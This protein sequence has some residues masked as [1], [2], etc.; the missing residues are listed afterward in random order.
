[1]QP[2]QIDI[3]SLNG[4][5]SPI[6]FGPDE[7][8]LYA[9]Q[10]DGAIV[11][12]DARAGKI[13]ATVMKASSRATSLAVDPQAKLL[14]AGFADGTVNILDLQS[15]KSSIYRDHKSGVISVSIRGSHFASVDSQGG[16]I[17]RT[18][19][20]GDS[21]TPAQ[22]VSAGESVKFT[23]VSVCTSFLA[24]GDDSGATR[25]YSLKGS[26]LISLKLGNSESESSL[27]IRA[28]AISPDGAFLASGGDTGE[29]KLWDLDAAEKYPQIEHFDDPI[30]ALAF[31]RESDSLSVGQQNTATVY[32]LLRHG[33]LGEV[34]RVFQTQGPVR[35]MAISGDFFAAMTGSETGR[36]SIWSRHSP[37]LYEFGRA[38]GL[39]G[40]ETDNA[41]I[42]R[43]AFSGD[44]RYL[45]AGNRAGDVL[46]WRIDEI[47]GATTYSGIRAIKPVFSIHADGSPK[48]VHGL[49]VNQN[50][51]GLLTS[52]QDGAIEQWSFP[53][54]MPS[55][56]PNVQRRVTDLC[57]LKDGRAISVGDSGKLKL[58]DLHAKTTVELSEPYSG[59]MIMR[60]SAESGTVMIGDSGGHVAFWKASKDS[61]VLRSLSQAHLG[62]VNA[63]AI[64]NDG[65]TGLSGGDDHKIFVWDLQTYDKKVMGGHSAAVTSMAF[66]NDRKFVLSGDSGRKLLFWD[67]ETAKE[68]LRMVD[69]DDVWEIAAS[70]RDAIF[71]VGRRDGQLKLLD[72]RETQ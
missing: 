54:V 13:L 32:Q 17:L 5:I 20:S 40:R 48:G 18:L 41:G 68:M 44:G 7:N 71:I 57:W 6:S 21:S 56:I 30:S 42:N 25:L 1:M 45:F 33:R 66:S 3:A 67:P 55:V 47:L 37:G 65:K 62:K 49:A 8:R 23:A 58:T 19:K 38:A 26:E 31:S 15:Q 50:G 16:M 61:F 52:G 63:I 36:V 51:D 29:L 2:Q 64:S 24:A 12:I 34:A 9:G 35:G 11:E 43:L 72:L 59:T 70:P 60:C 53:S 22:P 69:G 14:A 46:N 39:P 10:N 28:V 27:P 4:T